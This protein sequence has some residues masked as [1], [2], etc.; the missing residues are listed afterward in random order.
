M[1]RGA[2]GGPHTAPADAV[3]PVDPVD[4]WFDRVYPQVVGVVRRVLDR[5]G[6][7]P[8]STTL[9]EQVCTEAFS[10]RRGPGRDQE[11]ATTAVLGRALDLCLDELVGH[12]GSVPVR[13]EL[14]G[15]EFAAGDVVSLSELQTALSSMR[16]DDRRVG[17]LVLAAGYSPADA[18]ALLQV[19]L[20][21]V[22]GHLG[23]VGTRLEDGRRLGLVAGSSGVPR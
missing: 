2:H 21:E 19:P 15:D 14:V 12:P 1:S 9:A 20:D 11:R 5:D 6:R 16:R 17:L 23:R 8:S 3:D 4:A 7:V 22:L 13:P 10:R 18:A